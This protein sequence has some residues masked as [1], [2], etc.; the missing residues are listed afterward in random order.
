MG[1]AVLLSVPGLDQLVDVAAD[2]GLLDPIQR[3]NSGG[4]AA[5]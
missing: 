3:L 1:Q 2:Q 4:G 5:K